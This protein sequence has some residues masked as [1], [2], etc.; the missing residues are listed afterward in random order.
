MRFLRLLALLL[1]ALGPACGQSS[2]FTNPL[3]PAGADPWAI[4][5][6]GSYYY[7]HTTGRDLSIWKT[8]SLA[9]LG[10]ATKTTIWTPP[11]T[12]PYSK[13]I[14]A[15]ELHFLSGKWY[16]YFA[17]DGGNNN[18]HRLYVLENPA[19]DP[20][21]GKWTLKG[22]LKTPGNKW[23]I[24]GSVFE[25][26]GQLYALWSGWEG[27]EN[28]RQDIYIARLSNPWTISG[29]RV[30]I[31]DPRFGWEQHGLLPRFAPGEPAMV[32]VNEGPQF[33]ASPNGRLNVVYSA[34][35]CWTDFYALGLVWAEPG[36]DLLNPASWH[37]EPQPVFRA[38]HVKG[39][40]AAGHNS[41]FNS[42]NGK[43]HWIL[44]HANAEPGQGCGSD[45]SPRMQPFTFA[46]DGA[47]VFGDPLPLS[48][49]LSVP[50]SK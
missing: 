36:A 9:Q 47:P 5:H 26:K 33:L 11:V 16:V 20:T 40:Y 13:E 31:S 15:P 14:W 27:D 34:S 19:P 38:Q 28:G 25:S 22:E 3:L 8:A 35:G 29:P 50:D 41:F 43:Q 1:V 30:R 17:A 4:Y 2:T 6:A 44:Y 18:D 49:V 10:Q 21:T 42:P 45:R 7:M 39:T 23:A 32:L 48:E 37:K 24:D 12:G 46:A